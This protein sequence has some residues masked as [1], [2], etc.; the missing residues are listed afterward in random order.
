MW[1]KLLGVLAF[2]TFLNVTGIG[3]LIGRE[4]VSMA[5]HFSQPQKVEEQTA[6]Q[7]EEIAR[8]LNARGPVMLDNGVLW[9]RTVAGPGPRW[10]YH[11][12]YVD[13][14]ASEITAPNRAEA[15]EVL[16]DAKEL[17][18]DLQGGADLVYVYS[19]NDGVES[20]RIELSPSDCSY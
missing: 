10:T 17:E 3:S 13:Y 18:R 1:F 20:W 7:A 11:Y 6:E 15:V 19:G 12:T 5:S 8:E 9:T 16:C 4:L 2:L 14:P